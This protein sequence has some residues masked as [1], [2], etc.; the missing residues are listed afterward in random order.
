LRF[1]IIEDLESLQLLYSNILEG[2]D[3]QASFVARTGEAIVD[4]MDSGRVGELDGLI[5]DYRLTGMNGLDAAMKVVQYRPS[6]RVI[7][8]TADDAIE[9]EVLS[10]GF[11]YLKKPFSMAEFL[12]MLRK[13]EGP[14]DQRRGGRE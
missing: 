6:L 7:V 1:A 12:A 10:A 13:V 4:A 2:A 11:H 3:H 14:P 9:D 5:I 8:V